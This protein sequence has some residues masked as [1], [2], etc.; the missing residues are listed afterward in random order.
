MSMTERIEDLED[1]TFDPY[2]SDEL[3][4]GDLHDPYPR[5]TELLAQGPVVHGS[6]SDLMG[7][8]SMPSERWSDDY[9]VLSFEAVDEV[10]ND[11]VT[12]SNQA[13]EPTLG[14]GFGHTVSMMDPPEH[15]KYRKILQKA[16]RPNIVQEWGTD[17]VAP[18]VDELVSVFR[19]TGKAEL[20]EQFAR[21]YPFNVIYRMLGLPPE[22]IATFYKLT[23]A[24]IITFLPE[25]S[26]DA[27]T[28]LGRYFS[29]MIDERR[30]NPGTDVVSVVATTT[31]DGEP[32]PEDVAISF[33]RQL[34]NAGGDT[35]F[36]TTTVLLTG[37]FTNPDQ[38]EAV[39]EDRSLVAAAVE[40]ALRWDGPVLASARM[41][42]TDTVIAGVPVPKNA[43]LHM[44][45][46]AA[47]HD[48]AVFEH[49]EHFD[50][51]RPKHRHFGFAFGAHNCLGQM[52]ARL[53]MTRAVNAILDELPNVRLD[54]DYPSPY[55]RGAAMR[56]P[57]E[58]RVVFDS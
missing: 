52:L 43:Y 48:P 3:I 24:Q 17:I 16:F 40:E 41:T 22:D 55:P 42:T 28:K 10:L 11:P 58:I 18:V 14:A 51:F 54:P 44:L 21:P 19:D 5:L 4:F 7:I 34:I 30:A 25:N 20:V 12:F 27:S 56:T 6:Y 57:K 8:P 37:L 38:L 33:L 29:R 9:M 31:V 46:G 45:Y 15:T 39:R 1:K 13:F 47:N 49:P 32:L 50:I 26:Q 35:T 2:L 23:L 53:E 36:R